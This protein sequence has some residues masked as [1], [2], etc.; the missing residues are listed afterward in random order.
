MAIFVP[1][2]LVV[3]FTSNLCNLFFSDTGNNELV[4]EECPMEINF[5]RKL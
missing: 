1:P 4:S 3:L 2:H 5:V